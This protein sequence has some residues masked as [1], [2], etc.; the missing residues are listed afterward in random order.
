MRTIFCVLKKVFIFLNRWDLGC[1]WEVFGGRSS[2]PDG[3]K[4]H[5]ISN[6]G[7]IDNK[8]DYNKPFFFPLFSTPSLPKKSSPTTMAVCPRRGDGEGPDVVTVDQCK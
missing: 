4:C 1:C 7:V 3:T 5:V 8:A 6:Y 2:S